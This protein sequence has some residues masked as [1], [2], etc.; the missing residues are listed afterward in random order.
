MPSVT[1][2]GA[3]QGPMGEAGQ[4]PSAVRSPLQPSTQPSTQP[5]PQ[6]PIQPPI[7]LPESP[8]TASPEHS[9]R[10]QSLILGELAQ[11]LNR[12]PQGLDPEAR[13]Q[14]SVAHGVVLAQVLEP[15]IARSPDGQPFSAITGLAWQPGGDRLVLMDAQGAVNLYDAQGKW[16]QTLEASNLGPAL[17]LLWNPSGN[18]LITRHGSSKLA[19]WNGSG[20]LL[21]TVSVP[22]PIASGDAIAWGW[23]PDGQ[24]LAIAHPYQPR[25]WIWSGNQRQPASLTLPAIAHSLAWQPQPDGNLDASKLA[26]GLG[27]GTI[28][29]ASPNAQNAPA[30][31]LSLDPKPW[32][33]GDQPIVALAWRSDGQ[34]LASVGAT[35]SLWNRDGKILHRSGWPETFPIGTLSP[36]FRPVLQWQPEGNLLALLTAPRSNLWGDRAN[37]PPAQTI[38]LWQLDP[39]QNQLQWVRRLEYS[40]GAFNAMTWQPD[41]SSLL[42]GDRHGTVRRWPLKPSAQRQTLCDNSPYCPSP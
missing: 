32:Q 42:T 7:P 22:V 27:D 24:Q 23:R 18:Q 40:Q 10:S 11:L 31:P 12:V 4:T 15:L 14:V 34:Q 26:I 30:V 38:G 5:S 25:L 21:K 39:G 36:A 1:V 29:I 3:T 41:G 9:T 16:L 33:A 17:D 8:K 20:E 6:P 19:W 28:V 2:Q 37:S 35:L 13:V